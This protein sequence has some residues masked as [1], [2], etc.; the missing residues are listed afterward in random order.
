MGRGRV[1]E[2]PLGPGADD[3]EIR[4]LVREALDVV[5]Q[6]AAKFD[7][8]AAEAVGDE[9]DPVGLRDHG[10]NLVEVQL[11]GPSVGRAPPRR[12]GVDGHRP[13]RD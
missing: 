13:D 3:A 4:D 6:I 8:R 9:V 12:G 2:A 7:H 5:R 10:Q 11:Q 1:G